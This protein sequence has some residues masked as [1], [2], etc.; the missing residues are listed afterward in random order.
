MNAQLDQKEEES[1]VARDASVQ[2]PRNK[3]KHIKKARL[4]KK[5]NM[6]A[7]MVGVGVD[8]DVVLEALLLVWD[9]V[10]DV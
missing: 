1:G 3:S 4:C 9:E 8:V 5:V 2:G 6:V 10:R 7:G